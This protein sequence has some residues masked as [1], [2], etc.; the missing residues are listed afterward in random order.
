MLPCCLPV[1]CLL[2]GM[3]RVCFDWSQYCL[4]LDW[5]ELWSMIV[6]LIMC[7]VLVLL[8][9]WIDLVVGFVCMLVV[10]VIYPWRRNQ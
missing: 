10:G 2:L 4:R 5:I 3:D 1:W 9:N 8:E 6:C 7:G